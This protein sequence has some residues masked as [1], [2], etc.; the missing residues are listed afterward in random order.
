MATLPQDALPDSTS[1]ASGPHAS[2]AVCKLLNA[3]VRA[4]AGVKG[5]QEIAME[6]GYTPPNYFLMILN[7]DTRLPLDKVQPLA[8]A[9]QVDQKLLF[10]LAFDAYFPSLSEFL[11]E[12]L[13][14]DKCS[15]MV[16][17]KPR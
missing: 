15:R 5:P 13:D 10:R 9:L 3:K 14:E 12:I 1:E 16:P 6:L 8:K 11:D 4:L 7:G 17:T 2:S